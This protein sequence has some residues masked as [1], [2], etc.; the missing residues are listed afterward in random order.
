[1]EHC[2]SLWN[3]IEGRL[4]LKIIFKGGSRLEIL[5]FLDTFDA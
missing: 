2:G 1:M 3:F 5:R 4:S